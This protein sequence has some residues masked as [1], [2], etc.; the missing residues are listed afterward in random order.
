MT[1]RDQEL[2][3]QGRQLKKEID[4]TYE[5]L[6]VALERVGSLKR[7]IRCKEHS[8]SSIQQQLLMGVGVGGELSSAEA[9]KR[10][11]LMRAADDEDLRSDDRRGGGG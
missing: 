8:L 4:A 11:R 7:A 1:E 6:Y 9:G 5:V 2:I 10:S 3:K